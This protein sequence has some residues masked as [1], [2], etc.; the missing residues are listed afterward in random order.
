MKLDIPNALVNKLLF[1][2]EG[3][4]KN[5]GIEWDQTGLGILYGILIQEVKGRKRISPAKIAIKNRKRI[6]NS[7][8]RE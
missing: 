2:L 8:H 3:L 7:F 5:G 4:R 1:Q 6:K